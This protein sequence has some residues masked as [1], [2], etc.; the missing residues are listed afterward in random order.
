MQA[1]LCKALVLTAED[2]GEYDREYR[3][4][5]VDYGMV[6]ARAAGVRRP[7]AKMVSL[8]NPGNLVELE[9]TL[10]KRWYRIGGGLLIADYS[11]LRGSSMYR[12]TVELFELLSHILPEEQAEPRALSVLLSVLESF[13]MVSAAKQALWWEY[14]WWQVLG[15][16]G[17]TPDW[18]VSA[19][20]HQSLP[21]DG[22]YVFLP[23]GGG[24][25]EVS[26]IHPRYRDAVVP[27]DRETWK[28]LR[29]LGE[30]D[31]RIVDKLVVNK[32]VLAQAA[33]VRSEYGQFLRNQ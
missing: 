18:T 20:S 25:C 29:L 12:G 30:H 3:L 9:L 26:E 11:S 8:L 31:L 5:T 17:Y 7:G 2:R 33:R 10:G 19:Q 6:R 24:V 16:M 23:S 21:T 27:V 1:K 13:P 32:G 14:S 28:L 4:F 22:Q 15:A